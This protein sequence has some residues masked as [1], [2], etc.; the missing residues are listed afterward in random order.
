MY[1]DYY[2]QDSLNE[3]ILFQVRFNYLNRGSDYRIEYK[4]Y[5][6]VLNQK[7]YMKSQIKKLI[8]Q[9]Q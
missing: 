7:Y 3:H 4:D 5:N 2:E 6:L 8:Y 1:Y 9:P